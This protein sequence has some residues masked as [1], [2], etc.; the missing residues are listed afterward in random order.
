VTIAKGA[1]ESTIPAENIESVTFAGEPTELAAA[2][3]AVH[4]GRYQEA[5][6]ALQKIPADNSR[7]EEMLADIDFYGAKAQAQLALVGQGATDAAISDVRRFMSR[8]GKSYH[9]PE[10][11]EL[12][13]NL[14]SAAGQFAN[15]RTEYAKLTKARSPYYEAKS[16]LLQGRAWQAEGDHAKALS[17]FDKVAASTDQD[18]LIKS[19]R[20]AATLDRSISQAANGQVE[21]AT[22]TIGDIIAKADPEDSA[23]L[24][25]AYLALGDSYFKSGDAR[26]AL[27]AY[28]HVDLLYH[29]ESE[30]HAKALHE[31]VGL[32]KSVGNDL[33]S[34][35]TAQQLAAKYPNSKWAKP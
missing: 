32:W 34:Q 8:H 25:R 26:G 5:L 24:A 3:N 13:G 16:A 33:R 12:V 29:Q 21:Q 9:I 30:A 2:R 10:A 22:K 6:D 17:E 18:P 4:A 28:L 27:F 20:L 31:L 35:E 19:L 11:V 7:R 15:A 23:L 14:L 1:V